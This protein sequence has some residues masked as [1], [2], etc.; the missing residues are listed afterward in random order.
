M[1][2]WLVDL[3]GVEMA[4]FASWALAAAIVIILLL[5]VIA[6]AKKALGG[7]GGARAKGRGPRL[8]VMDVAAIDQKRKLVLVR[9]DEVEHLLLIGGQ[10]DLVVE[11]HILR[12]PASVRGSRPEPTLRPEPEASLAPDRAQPAIAPP[13]A[14]AQAQAPAVMTAPLPPQPA[15]VPSPRLQPSAA[16][17]PQE[18]R[19]QAASPLSRPVPRAPVNDMPLEAS[20]QAPPPSPANAAAP[21][22]APPVAALP[23]GSPV[24]PPVVSPAADPASV[25]APAVSLGEPPRDPSQRREPTME[26]EGE[27]APR[28]EL[29]IEPDTA[30]D[31][32]RQDVVA[33]S[34]A[35]P[36][37]EPFAPP[38]A[39]RQRTEPTI[40]PSARREDRIDPVIGDAPGTIAAPRTV[41]AEPRAMEEAPPLP[42]QAASA[43]GRPNVSSPRSPDGIEA[44]AAAGPGG[45]RMPAAPAGEDDQ[46]AA[47]P[48]EVQRRPSAGTARMPI[49]TMPGS[50]PAPMRRTELSPL[51]RTPAPLGGGNAGAPPLQRTPIGDGAIS[52]RRPLTPPPAAAAGGTMSATPRPETDAPLQAPY[53]EATTSP[54]SSAASWS[55]FEQA[56]VTVAAA[57]GVRPD[58]ARR[59][60]EAPL[61][62]GDPA[63]PAP[64]RTAPPF[65]PSPLPPVPAS[66]PSVST[67]APAFASLGTSGASSGLIAA[68]E[69]QR[70]ALRNRQN[71]TVGNP[72]DQRP[73]SP[74][75]VP[76]TPTTS[77]TASFVPPPPPPLDAGV[78]PGASDE[79]ADRRP[80]SVKSFA[81]T[82]QS[83]KPSYEPPQPASAPERGIDPSRLAV[84]PASPEPASQTTPPSS[85]LSVP[86]FVSRVV[87]EQREIEP[88][89]KPA[90]AP[91]GFAPAGI[92][93][94][95]VAASTT[96]GG[97]VG[98]GSLEDFLSA[99]LDSDFG[100]L[101]WD[102]EAP[103]A[104]TAPRID[105]PERPLFVPEPAPEP[106]AE[107]PPPRPLTLEEE[108]E[109]L[110][111][112]FDFDVSDRKAK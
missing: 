76:P 107:T 109:R 46:P 53:V 99:E 73:A 69:R 112:D 85:R 43:S 10:N 14:Q 3:V 70:E 110:L 79:P 34:S 47:V 26:R 1:R 74:A 62:A 93:P 5:V 96:G 64:A 83:M 33:N 75:F 6:I 106:A 89:P 50:S 35:A 39:T 80:L 45:S 57:D 15:R 104:A 92:A 101:S 90:P 86:P 67:A 29:G 87:N 41:I 78:L 84:P 55:P 27:A 66:S 25:A 103:R 9:R 65:A 48:T 8:A 18:A 91:V 38:S 81:T 52:A 51:T 21:I 60:A 7:S 49:D 12:V 13:P 22:I 32:P 61:S 37:P 24:A 59:T 42:P 40:Q 11:P 111:G 17:K 72:A 36:A 16:Q 100:N 102:E 58:A 108:M 98:D 54:S 68:A 105:P 19:V 31:A 71:A 20:P 77:S 23:V 94:M 30:T 28:V 88:L 97:P 56:P 4:P 82:I 44:P 95:T 63:A 2:E